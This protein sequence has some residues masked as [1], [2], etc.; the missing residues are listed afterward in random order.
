MQGAAPSHERAVVPGR[1]RDGR[2]A[3]TTGA[4]SVGPYDR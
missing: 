3:V 4:G 2:R 1:H